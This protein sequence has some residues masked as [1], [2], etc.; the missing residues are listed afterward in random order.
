M[1][2]T[3]VLKRRRQEK[4]EQT[5][6]VPA[7]SSNGHA[8]PA[9]PS[10]GYGRYAAADP[11]PQVVS[12]NQL[13]AMNLPEPVVVVP[14]LIVEGLT[15]FVGKPK[16]GKSF[17]ALDLGM[18]VAS[19]RPALNARA[20]PTG[21]VLYIAAE[22]NWRRLRDRLDKMLGVGA[23]VGVGHSLPHRFFLQTQCRPLDQGGFADIVEWLDAHPETRMIIIDPLAKIRPARKSSQSAYDGD[24]EALGALQRLA[25]ERHIAIVIVHH[26]RK[27]ASLDDIFDD[28]SGTQALIGCADTT[29]IMRRQRGDTIATLFVTGRDVADKEFALQFNRERFAWTLLGETRERPEVLRGDK[30]VVWDVLARGGKLRPSEIANRSEEI[31]RQG[32]NKTC[33]RLFEDGMIA[34]DPDGHYWIQRTFDFEGAQQETL[35]PS[36]EGA[37]IVPA[38][39]AASPSAPMGEAVLD[40]GAPPA[41]SLGEGERGRRG[42]GE[43]E[44]AAT[45]HSP[46]T[47]HHS[48]VEPAAAPDVGFRL[49]VA[50]PATPDDAPLERFDI[51]DGRLIVLALANLKTRG[52]VTA[53][54]AAIGLPGPLALE[55][56]MPELAGEPAEQIWRAIQSA[57]I[58]GR[59]GEGEKV[60][61]GDES[62]LTTSPTHSPLTTEGDDW[63]AIGLG[64]CMNDPRLPLIRCQ[65][66]QQQDVRTLGELDEALEL[67]RLGGFRPQEIEQL[68]AVIEDARAPTPT[69][70][71]TIPFLPPPPISTGQLM[72]DQG[73]PVKR[74]GGRARRAIQQQAQA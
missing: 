26:T 66:L 15:L 9:T 72:P 28:V 33:Q 63:R 25:I 30:K 73:P 51:S 32:A 68:R 71:R 59:R 24:Y 39:A 18:A 7:P 6:G 31:S 49:R 12:A 55:Q 70:A 42:E 3:N 44:I 29:L 35:A 64:D 11:R 21:D 56:A 69:P 19:G 60:R 5:N 58:R 37:K 48:P 14:D 74:G 8:K 43:T 67:R 40:A 46:L 10:N 4:A 17:I 20:V 45:H 23:G 1:M 36:R 54:V 13:A 61:T 27:I 57:P 62:P 38:G 16:F 41:A 65:R 47:T 34:R 53:L 52:D 22:D 2:R 50:K